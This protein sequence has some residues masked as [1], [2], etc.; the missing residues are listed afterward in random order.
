MHYQFLKHLHIS[1]VVIS[2]CLF[3]LRFYW[4]L[5]RND[6]LQQKWVRIAPHMIDTLLLSCALGMLWIAELNPFTHFWLFGKILALMGYIVFGYVAIHNQGN[7]DGTTRISGKFA[8]LLGALLCF[9]II[10]RLAINKH[11]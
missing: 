8:A 1:C 2:F 5:K 6:L 3:L 7:E 10:L 4:S 11:I 9:S